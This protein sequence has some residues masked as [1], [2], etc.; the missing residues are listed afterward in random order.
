MNMTTNHER[1][2]RCLQASLLAFL[3]AFLLACAVGLA[4]TPA[5]L[6]AD[7]KASDPC[8]KR[9]F[10]KTNSTGRWLV[11]EC[12]AGGSAHFQVE[13]RDSRLQKY[14][15]SFSDGESIVDTNFL[16]LAPDTLSIELGAER[17]GRVILLH[18]VTAT[19]E[20]SSLKVPYMNP[21]QGGAFHLKQ[22]GNTIR[23][24]TSV[25]DVTVAVDLEGR[26]S[27]VSKPAR[28]K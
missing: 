8:F 13:F 28:K 3:L 23:L 12:G 25:D 17:G 1:G 14:A 7:M 21:D 9:V 2:L 20:L 18:P 11:K 10:E 4:A 16:L 24:Q 19:G 6:A 26:L 15:A 5:V 27:M 22:N